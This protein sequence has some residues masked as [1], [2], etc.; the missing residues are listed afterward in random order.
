[1]MFNHDKQRVT[2]QHLLFQKTNS[3][4]YLAIYLISL[5]TLNAST[6][7]YFG[8]RISSGKLWETGILPYLGLLWQQ[9][10]RKCYLQTL[11][12]KSM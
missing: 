7:K 3:F 12:H 2:T 4:Y 9:A 8:L 1:M 5:L 11:L 10:E 6:G